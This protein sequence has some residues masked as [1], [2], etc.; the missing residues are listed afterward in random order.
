MQ[1]YDAVTTQAGLFVQGGGCT[2]VG[3]AGLTQSGGFWAVLQELRPSRGGSVGKP[4]SSPQTARCESPMPARI[5]ICSGRSK[6]AEEGSFGV[7]TRLTLRTRE[8]PEYFGG[9]FGTIQVHSETA[10][11]SLIARIVS[12]YHEQ[13]FNRHWGEQIRFRPGN[14]VNIGMVFQG[15]NQRQAEDVWR[16]LLT[17]VAKTP[18]D[19]AWETPMQIVALPARHFWDA[20]FLKQSA[21]QFIVVDDRPGASEGNFFWAG[22]HDEAGQFLHGYRSAWLPASLLEKDQQS[23]L[24]DALFAG[25]RYWGISL[26][27]NKGLAGAS[28][29][30]LVAAKDTAMNPVVLDAFAEAIIAGESPST[31]PSIPGHEPDL[32]A[33]RRHA[34]A[35]NRAMDELLKGW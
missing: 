35:I 23:V 5:R 6:G 26:H 28:S 22:N 1:V 18:Q 4:K 31:F 25:S 32:R 3:V 14:I 16:P 17:W 13:L 12:F 30:H 21:P 11:R 7:V 33:A 19:F 29:N 10:F 20:K 8:L 9:V 34:S 24:V 2:T 27:F 15:L